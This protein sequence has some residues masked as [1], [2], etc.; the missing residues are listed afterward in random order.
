[1][2]CVHVQVTG[3]A[4]GAQVGHR[5]GPLMGRHGGAWL[6]HVGRETGASRGDAL[7][8]AAS[9]AAPIRDHAPFLW[10]EL[11]G[12]AR[13]SRLLMDRLLLLQA[14][15]EVMR[16]SKDRVAPPALECT[17]FAVG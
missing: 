16:L 11:E 2:A 9:Y 10:E 3:V 17:T 5:F 8:T 1:M 7:A 13:G 4:R 12:M 15:A 14:R 6:D